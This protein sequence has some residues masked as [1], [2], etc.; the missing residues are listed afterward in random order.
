V[1]LHHA[2]D[3]L[4][5]VAVGAI[6]AAGIELKDI[7]AIVVNTITGVA[8]PSLDA[9]LVNLLDLPASVERLPIFGSAAAVALPD[10]HAPPAMRRRCPELTFCFSPSTLQSLPS[11]Q[12]SEHGHVRVGSAVRRWRRG[13]H[14]AQHQGRAA[15]S[16]GRGRILAARDTEH[17]M[18]WDIRHDGF[19]VVLSPE[20]PQLLRQHLK[21][22][23]QD[24]LDASGMSLGEFPSCST[25][26]PP[27]CLRPCSG[28][29]T[30]GA[31]ILAIHGRCCATSEAGATGPHLMAAFGHGFSAYFLL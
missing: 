12:R 2:L 22:A 18:G 20:L 8:I 5:E 31:T 1:F 10:L 7:G 9:K 6:R 13:R 16:G 11:C 4:Q 24:F 29:S 30:S 21:P 15:H 25:R 23:V 14:A 3:L 28:C 27:R 17:I 26:E 19:G